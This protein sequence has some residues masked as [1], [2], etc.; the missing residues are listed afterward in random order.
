MYK[1]LV[2]NTGATDEFS[3]LHRLFVEHFGIAVGLTWLASGVAALQAPWVRNL[4][5]LIDPGSR[6]ESTFSFLFGLPLL[7]TLGWLGAAFGADVMRRSQILRSQVLEF[8]IAG[9]VAFAVFCMALQ[10]AV[11]AFWLAL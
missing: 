4:R 11:A 7:M 9:A 8:G 2:R 3:R 5:G 10:R 1:L 6:P